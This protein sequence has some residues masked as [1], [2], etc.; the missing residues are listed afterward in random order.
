MIPIEER[1]QG[2]GIR[3]I[4][5]LLISGLALIGM[6]LTFW[7][8]TNG[9]G[10]DSD[11]VVY[12]ICAKNILTGH[13]YSAPAL[14]ELG[15]H[16]HNFTAG[17]DY[18]N[19]K[20]IGYFPPLFSL[21]IATFSYLG[22]DPS[23]SVR[24][25]NIILYGLNIL[26]VFYLIKLT[27]HNYYISPLVGTLFMLN[28]G[29][30]ALHSSTLSEPLFLFFGFAALYLLFKYQSSYNRLYL[31]ISGC[32][33]VLSTL[34][35]YV[36]ISFFLTGVA[37]LLFFRKREVIQRLI[38]A[39]ILSIIYIIPLTVWS[40]RNIWLADT[41][42]GRKISIHLI[43]LEPLMKYLE[44]FTKWFFVSNYLTIG[45]LSITITSIVIIYYTH[46]YKSI[47]TL[48]WPRFGFNIND[49]LVVFI[50]IYSV[51]LIITCCFLDNLITNDRL[52][53]RFFVPIFIATIPLLTS[54][55]DK[56]VCLQPFKVFKSIFIMCFLI[57]M[58]FQG[59]NSLKYCH[60]AHLNGIGLASISWKNSDTFEYIKKLPSDVKIFANRPE[61][62]LLLTGRPAS[63]LPYIRE[64][65]TLFPNKY[66][67]MELDY[68]INQSNGIIVWFINLGNRHVLPENTL[69]NTNK[70]YLIEK[71]QD[72]RIYKI[73]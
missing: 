60:S 69:T 70:I 67:E 26:M 40:L 29:M 28:P 61:T 37:S 12:Y 58:I 25:I 17:A 32:C 62:I 8:T 59:I 22:M 50:V 42:T 66:Y 68:L 52:D 9:P 56:L 34:T 63:R 41:L 38:D 54:I 33:F 5:S 72:S 51:I 20:P 27:P 4:D 2:R 1:L 11:G 6:A 14:L 13:G 53:P 21:S 45:L 18:I 19:N 55:F 47:P 48:L 24:Y 35:R 39:T 23:D 49:M 16:I 10:Y 57:I 64:P 31:I 44:K 30:I 43:G 36:G 73:K 3:R 65:L 7:S 15:L 71:T 46:K